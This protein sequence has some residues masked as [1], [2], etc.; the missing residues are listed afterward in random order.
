M[1]HCRH[2]ALKLSCSAHA[3]TIGELQSKLATPLSRKPLLLPVF[4]T[5]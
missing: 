3:R 2:T 1:L 4:W 5:Y